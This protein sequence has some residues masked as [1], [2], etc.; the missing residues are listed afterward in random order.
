[1]RLRRNSRLFLIF[2]LSIFTV[3]QFYLTLVAVEVFDNDHESII[4]DRDLQPTPKPKLF[5]VLLKRRHVRED[6][7]FINLCVDDGYLM[8]SLVLF[9]TLAKLGSRASFG[10]MTEGLSERSKMLLKELKIHVFEIERIKV[11]L[12]FASGSQIRDQKLFNKLRVWELSQFKKVVLLDSDIVVRANIDDL[13]IEFDEYTASPIIH[14]E[15]KISFYVHTPNFFNSSTKYLKADVKDKIVGQYGANSGVTV[16]RPSQKTFDH[17]MEILTQVKKRLCC[18]SQEFLYHYFLEFG[19]LTS[20]PFKYHYR[21]RK[22]IDLSLRDELDQTYRIYHFV[23]ARKPWHH[24]IGKTKHS[25]AAMWWE[26][27]KELV[28][29]IESLGFKDLELIK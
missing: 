7:A 29:V 5:D 21:C 3:I 24:V 10:I 19:N 2:F 14:G 23:E 25:I 20:L 12:H 15:E 8:H 6:I 17:M 26:N 11:P 28:G 27:R 13:F 9:H 22:L 18:P 4:H 1:M 16:L